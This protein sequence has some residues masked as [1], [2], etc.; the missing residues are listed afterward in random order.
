M[1]TFATIILF[2]L[3]TNACATRNA[4]E[5]FNITQEQAKSEDSI[6]NVKIHK[7]EKITGV[8]SA[9]YLN[10]VLSK[11]YKDNEYFY[12]ILYDRHK[13]TKE[14]IKFLLNGKEAISVEVLEAKNRFSNLISS[15][16]DWKLYYLVTFK[17]QG[18]KLKLK[19]KIAKHKS[20][21]LLFK[22]D[23]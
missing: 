16:S 19:V 22:K 17:E 5:S 9:I 4:F 14:K 10:R 20:D 7:G 11:E 23:N 13:K 18:S 2:M 21:K 15:N 12:I 3:L 6:L 8:M 1:K